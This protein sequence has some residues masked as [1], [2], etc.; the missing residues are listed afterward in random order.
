MKFRD[1]YS[2]AADVA[3]PTL[4]LITDTY[5]R[6]WRAVALPGSSQSEYQV[7][8]AD[9]TL[10]AVPLSTGHHAIRLEY[11]PSGWTIGRWI[12]LGALALYLCAAGWF[13]AARKVRSPARIAL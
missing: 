3:Q 10:M 12:S 5:S 6:Y 8:L 2:I 4:L 11:A 1:S 13:L 9:Y 7:L